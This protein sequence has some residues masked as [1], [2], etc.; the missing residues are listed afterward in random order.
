MNP[1]KREW[2]SHFVAQSNTQEISVF[3]EMDQTSQ[4]MSAKASLNNVN[5]FP[6]HQI[7]YSL[8]KMV[9]DRRKKSL[10]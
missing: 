4:A 7:T 2:K 8:S 9:K 1:M 6:N 5:I 3:A 10:R